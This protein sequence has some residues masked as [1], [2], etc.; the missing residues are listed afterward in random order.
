MQHRDP[1]PIVSYGPLCKVPIIQTG[2]V[3]ERVAVY[4]RHPH[5][6]P[7]RTPWECNTDRCAGPLCGICE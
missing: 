4:K 5:S 2:A 3:Q 6:L 7:V 1:V